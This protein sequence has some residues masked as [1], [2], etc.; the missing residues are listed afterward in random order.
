MMRRYALHLTEGLVHGLRRD[1]GFADLRD[2]ALVPGG[3]WLTRCGRGLA[4]KMLRFDR[5]EG[6]MVPTCLL[7][8]EKPGP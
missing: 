2:G 7:C 6:E 8:A 5:G 1:E 4:T 3:F